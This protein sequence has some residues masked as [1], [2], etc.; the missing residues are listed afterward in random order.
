MLQAIRTN[1]RLCEVFDATEQRDG[2]KQEYGQHFKQPQ[3]QQSRDFHPS[4]A[5]AC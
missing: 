2:H 5:G 4:Q 1:T 3:N